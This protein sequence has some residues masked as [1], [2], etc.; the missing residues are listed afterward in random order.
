M[1]VIWTKMKL[2]VV[3]YNITHKVLTAVQ[4]NCSALQ[5]NSQTLSAILSHM[6]IVYCQPCGILLSFRASCIHKDSLANS[7]CKSVM[8]KSPQRIVTC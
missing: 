5:C 8:N 4:L 3:G 1:T 7:A 6:N 2:D